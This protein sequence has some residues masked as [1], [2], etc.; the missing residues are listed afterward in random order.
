MRRGAL[1]SAKSSAS[2]ASLLASDPTILVLSEIGFLT[3]FVVGPVKF[4][5]GD[6]VPH[7]L[8]LQQTNPHLFMRIG[9]K[10]GLLL[11]ALLYDVAAQH[12]EAVKRLAAFLKKIKAEGRSR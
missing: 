5:P 10:L 7:R 1:R 9:M 3:N 2:S 4:Y 6:C 11:A 12:P 8:L